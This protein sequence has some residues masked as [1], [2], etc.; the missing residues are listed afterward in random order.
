MENIKVEEAFTFL[1]SNNGGN[2][3]N[4]GSN[5]SNMTT[6][7]TATGGT[8]GDGVY[9]SATASGKRLYGVLVEQAALKEASMLYFQDQAESLELNRRMKVLL[10]EHRQKQKEKQQQ[11]QQMQD[12][13]EEEEENTTTTNGYSNNNSTNDKKRQAIQQETL[14]DGGSNSPDTK[15]P[16]HEEKKDNDKSIIET[17]TATATTTATNNKSKDSPKDGN[18]IT[19]Y[20]DEEQQAVQKFRYVEGSGSSSS[21]GSGS[22]NNFTTTAIFDDYRVLVATFCN[23]K[24]AAGGNIDRERSITAACESGG[25]F[26]LEEQEQEEQEQSNNSNNTTTTPKQQ[27]YYYQYEVLPASLQSQSTKQSILGIDGGGFEMRTSMGF[28]SFLKDTNLPPWFPLSNLQ[29]GNSNKV[30]GMLNMKRDNSGNVIWDQM[31]N[32]NNGGGGANSEVSLMAAGTRLPMHPRPNSHSYEIG[33]IGGG[34][35]GL[36]C[37][38]ELVTMLQNDNINARVTLLEARDRF[39]GRLWTESMGGSSSSSNNNNNKEDVVEESSETTTTTAAAI[40]IELGAQWIHGIDDNPLAALSKKAKCDFIT[41]SEEVTMLGASGERVDSKMD[42][43]MGKLFD[44][45]LDHAAEDCW[46]VNDEAEGGNGGEEGGNDSYPENSQA[47]IK[48][49]SS[50]FVDKAREEGREKKNSNN[51]NLSNEDASSSKEKRG[52]KPVGVPPHRRSTDRSVDYEIGRAISKHKL[53]QVSK[54][55]VAEQRMLMWNTKNVE[56]ALGANISDLSMKYWDSD[57]RHAFE[58]DH[59]LLRQGYSSVI[60]HMLAS[61]Q[62]AGKDRFQHVLN[63]PVG[64]VEYARKS[65]TKRYSRDARSRLQRKLVDLSD[66]CSVTSQDGKDTR[67]FDF[68]VCAVPLGVLKEATERNTEAEEQGKLTN[69][70]MFVPS[71]PFSKIDAITNVG[72]GLL[73]KVFLQFPT[74]FWR[75]KE[76]FSEVG[77]CLFGNVTGVNPHHYM[78]FDVGK[79]LGNSGGNSPAILMS[80]ISGKEA[81]ACECLSDKELVAE[82]METLRKIFSHSPLP[83]PIAFRITRWGKDPYSRGSY[84]FLPP[85]ATDQGKTIYTTFS[86]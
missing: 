51:I 3:N 29:L 70:L 26:V 63:F 69:K 13:Q 46:G 12:Q 73:D 53:R 55:G 83:E 41:A 57:E 86:S 1:G 35:A 28:H 77:Q 61:L 11:Q 18:P 82:T 48:W 66:T 15:R 64:K 84:T 47:A 40:P 6:A 24:E 56:Y 25:N 58:G 71:L 85:G 44:D 38:Q 54:L 76:I 59:V 9:V 80:L 74:A 14:K 10:S 33:V 78:F 81:V 31:Y 34:I 30:L 36:A 75:D 20:D 52:P 39:G 60:Q 32:S 79:C 5:N 37:C 50:V 65:V 72:F 16:R 23:I 45:L 19:S 22:G 67:Y 27:Y 42:D 43:N 68:L 4:N 7:M 62:Q 49:Y 21:G 8:M 2:N 17:T